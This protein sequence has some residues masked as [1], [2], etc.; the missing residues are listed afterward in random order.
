LIK[1]Q[2]LIDTDDKEQIK[3][4][5]EG[6]RVGKEYVDLLPKS[7]SK[8]TFPTYPPRTASTAASSII[9]LSSPVKAQRTEYTTTG[10]TS[11]VS[12]TITR[13][14]SATLST[15]HAMP[16]PISSQEPSTSSRSGDNGSSDLTGHH[17][18]VN[19]FSSATVTTSVDHRGVKEIEKYEKAKFKQNFVSA[20]G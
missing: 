5:D 13:N 10:S 15:A 1:R 19:T 18:N 16:E 2:L 7:L 3:L 17:V 8:E 4:T 6:K 11:S 9:D 12:D 14:P 20:H